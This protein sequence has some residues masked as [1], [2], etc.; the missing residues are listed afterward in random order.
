M[1]VVLHCV[2]YTYVFN[3]T[4]STNS[5]PDFVFGYETFKLLKCVTF[6]LTYTNHF[7]LCFFYLFVTRLFTV[8]KLVAE[9][10]HSLYA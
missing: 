7:S 6:I 5:S 2:N 4:S 1:A 9:V 3:A 8:C 10:K